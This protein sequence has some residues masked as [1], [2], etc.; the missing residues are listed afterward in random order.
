MKDETN[1]LATYAKK[2]ILDSGDKIFFFFINFL[3]IILKPFRS[4]LLFT[5]VFMSAPL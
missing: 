4:N 5:R 2:E 3:F 1:K